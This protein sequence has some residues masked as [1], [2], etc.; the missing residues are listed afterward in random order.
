[1]ILVDTSVWVAY[2]RD[3]GTSAVDELERLLSRE[4]ELSITEPV[5][6][7]LL[8][9]ARR[10]QELARVEALVNGLPLTPLES[11][12]DFVDAARLYRASAMNGHPVRSM[13]D[14]LIAA[15]AIRRDVPLLHQ[16]RDFAYL[17]EISRLRLHETSDD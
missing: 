7:E 14:C 5:M 13:T 9:G 17:A 10:P 2:L 12:I 4:A 11:S 3:D 16:D 6:M 1:M 8:A 15:V